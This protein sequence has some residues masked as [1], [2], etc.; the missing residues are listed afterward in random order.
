MR[1]LLFV[2]ADSERK[3]DKAASSGADAL[4]ID[5]EDSVAPT[6]KPAA[7]QMARDY[8]AS[9]NASGQAGATGQTSPA[10]C[11]RINPLSGAYWTAD[12]AAIA[13]TPPD[14][15]ML[16]KARDGA[17]V[18]ALSS[19]LADHGMPAT[20]IIALVTE[21]PVSVL[22]LDSYVTRTQN[23]AALTWGAEDLS[24][25]LGATANRDHTGHFTSPFRIVRDLT[26]ITAAAAGVRA[27]DTV[28][29]NFRDEAGLFHEAETAAR[30]GFTGKLAIHPTQVAAINACFTPTA[31]QCDRA[32]AVLDA[33]EDA[34]ENAGVVSLDGE[35]IDEPHRRQAE[36]ILAAAERYQHRQN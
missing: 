2:P 32:R 30:D 16:P 35:M 31:A 33:F 21:V 14:Y 25:E 5:L 22:R 23:L 24:V 13:D 8:L 19:A 34:G 4:I 18:A 11:V 36:R 26:L 15:V 12:L 7:R 1:S 10:L 29:T 20:Q 28:F 27:I 17:D 3:L 9:Q 6:R